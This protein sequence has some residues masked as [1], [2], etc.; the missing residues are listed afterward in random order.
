[1]KYKKLLFSTLCYFFTV[2][3][4]NTSLGEI[5][6]RPTI[7]AK[8]GYFFFLDDTMSQVYNQGGLDVQLSTSYPVYVWKNRI[9]LDLYASIEYM[10]KNGHSL[11]RSYETNVWQIPVNVGLKPLFVI[12]S[13]MQYYFTLGPRYFYIH[14]HNNSKYVDKNSGKSGVGFF[15]NTGFNFIVWEHFLIDVFGEYSFGKVCFYTNKQNVYTR[16][17]QISGLTFGLGLGYSF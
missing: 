4:E 9:G 12:N 1:M 8:W 3:A 15:A 13:F 14:Q 10:Q 5:K 16:N 17:I 11:N 7:E 6:I 2:Y